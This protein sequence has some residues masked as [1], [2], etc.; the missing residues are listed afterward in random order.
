MTLRL[1]KEEVE[2]EEKR[3]FKK[4]NWDNKYNSNKF[5]V[6]GMLEQSNHIK[7][8]GERVT[9]IEF[10]FLYIKMNIEK[11]NITIYEKEGFKDEMLEDPEYKDLIKRLIKYAK[12]ESVKTIFK[13]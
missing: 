1:Q 13:T 12:Q 2:V 7:I 10:D 6:Y 3:G 9:V 8:N 4:V 11:R 5:F